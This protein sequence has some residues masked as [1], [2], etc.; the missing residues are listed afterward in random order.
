TSVE[1][2]GVT[3]NIVDTPGHAD[4]GGEVERIMHMV[5]GVLL[6]VDAVEGPMPQTRFVLRQALERGLPA[7][8][9]VNKIDRPAARP[10]YVV[11]AR[12]LEPRARLAP[13]QL[14]GSLE[15][16]F[17]TIVEYLPAPQIDPD[18]PTQLLVATIE[19][20]SYVGKIAIGRLQSGSIRTGQQ[21]LRMAPDGST[22]TA[23]VTQLYTF[24]NLQRTPV[25]EVSAGSIV[26]VAGIENV[27]IGDTLADPAD[28]RP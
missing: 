1:Y 14:T 11:N 15:P 3:I 24:R 10:D 2:K 28:P 5:D 26:A 16:L 4:F 27:G 8:V 21:I 17:D 18:G 25:P 13:D 20:S 6:L 9:V 12:A 7:I 19:Y 23:K 22:E